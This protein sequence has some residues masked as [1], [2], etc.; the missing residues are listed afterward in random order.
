MQMKIKSLPGKTFRLGKRV[1]VLA[2]V[3]YSAFKAF[4]HIGDRMDKKTIADQK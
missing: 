4:V 1:V 3:G 2:A